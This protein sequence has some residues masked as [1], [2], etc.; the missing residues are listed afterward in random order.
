[1]TEA[2]NFNGKSTAT[3]RAYSS[4]NLLNNLYAYARILAEYNLSDGL[5]V[6]EAVL[7]GSLLARRNSSPAVRQ[8]P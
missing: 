4:G 6:T 3:N 5:L 2:V 8:S 1:M 7:R